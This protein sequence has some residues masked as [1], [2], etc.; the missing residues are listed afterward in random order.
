MNVI[1]GFKCFL[2]YSIYSYSL[3][4]SC[5]SQLTRKM[6]NFNATIIVALTFNQPAQ[7]MAAQI[8]ACLSLPPSPCA[9]RC[10]G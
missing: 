9:I 3:S 7:T 5:S 10:V 2:I 4:L 6:Q 8:D 1:N